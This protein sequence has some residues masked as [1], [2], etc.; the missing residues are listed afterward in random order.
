[1]KQFIKLLASLALLIFMVALTGCANQSSSDDN[2]EEEYFYYDEKSG[3]FK[4]S[5]AYST[6]NPSMQALITTCLDEVYWKVSDYKGTEIWREYVNNG[7]NG[8]IKI[9]TGSKTAGVGTGILTSPTPELIKWCD[10]P[11]VQVDIVFTFTT[12][13]AYRMAKKNVYHGYK[14]VMSQNI[15]DYYGYSISTDDTDCEFLLIPVVNDVKIKSA[16]AYTKE[17]YTSSANINWENYYN[18]YEKVTRDDIG[19]SFDPPLIEI[20]REWIEELQC[21]SET[22]DEIIKLELKTLDGRS[23]TVEK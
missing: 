19:F 22:R 13:T 15:S 21:Y 1:M 4:G 3:L 12:G 23:I 6:Q 8:W 14:A 2:T 5:L 11:G 18:A 7:Q 17:G 16:K 20:K 9:Y 10:V